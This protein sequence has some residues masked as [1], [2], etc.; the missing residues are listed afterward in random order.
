MIDMRGNYQTVSGYP[1]RLLTVGAQGMYPVVGEYQ[2][3][4]GEW[5]IG[6]WKADG[7]HNEGGTMNL[8]KVVRKMRVRAWVVYNP[9]DPAQNFPCSSEIHARRT[10][11]DYDWNMIEMSTE[12]TVEE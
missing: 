12:V 2:N 11:N 6:V 1:V 9:K 5:R 3:H 4:A 10:A 8:Q 7:T